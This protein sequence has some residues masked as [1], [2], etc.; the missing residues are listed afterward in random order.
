MCFSVTAL[1]HEPSFRYEDSFLAVGEGAGVSRELAQ[2]SPP[3]AGGGVSEGEGSD[4]SEAAED[5]APYERFCTQPTID[6]EAWQ[7]ERSRL[8]KCERRNEV[9]SVRDRAG[10]FP[11]RSRLSGDTSAEAGGY[12]DACARVDRV[13]WGLV[14]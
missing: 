4:A 2:G 1:R 7:A 6:A 11:T 5:S 10:S 12:G 14:K 8:S 13:G 3:P 9:R